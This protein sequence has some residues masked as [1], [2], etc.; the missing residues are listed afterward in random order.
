MKNEIVK[1][2]LIK[3]YLRLDSNKNSLWIL[4]EIAYINKDILSKTDLEHLYRISE[5]LSKK[6][7]GGL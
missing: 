5:K 4:N 6:R 1:A 3:K 2:N 7:I